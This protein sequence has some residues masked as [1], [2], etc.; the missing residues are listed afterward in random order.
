MGTDTSIVS[1]T[2]YDG[3]LDGD[4]TITSITGTFQLL[5]GGQETSVMHAMVSA[6]D[7]QESLAGLSN[8]GSVAPTVSR[9]TTTTSVTWSITFNAISGDAKKLT[10]K[11]VDTIGTERQSSNL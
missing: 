4:A 10:F 1:L 9:S 7:M 2:F 11:Y 3:I 6:N 8:V 5:Y